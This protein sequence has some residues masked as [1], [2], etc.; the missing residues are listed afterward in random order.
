MMGAGHEHSGHHH[1]R[2]SVAR[3]PRARMSALDP[4]DAAVLSIARHFFQSFAHPP[5]E[6]WVRAFAHADRAFG[7][8]RGAI[9]ASAVLHSVQRMRE[10]RRSCF[11]FSNPDCVHCAEALSESERHFIG[12]FRAITDSHLS[13]AYGHALIL[14]EGNDADP[15]LRQLQALSDQ[16][17]AADDYAGIA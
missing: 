4:R 5:S 12:A 7:E 10:A 8:A 9:V 11:R 2:N 3:D 14:C 6:G 16:I 1:L 15:F 17:A 13:E